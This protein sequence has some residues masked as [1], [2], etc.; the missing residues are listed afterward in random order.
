MNT[1][2]DKSMLEIIWGIRPNDVLVCD[3]GNTATYIYG[4]NGTPYCDECVPRGCSCNHRHTKLYFVGISDYDQEDIDMMSEEPPPEDLTW[5][6]IEKDKIWAYTDDIGRFFPCCE[7][8]HIESGRNA[9][10]IK[11]EMK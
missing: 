2:N 4:P 6:W 9:T 11:K 5:K 10:E 3:C 7:Y 1:E 8:M